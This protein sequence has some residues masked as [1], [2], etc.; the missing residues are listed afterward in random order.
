KVGDTPVSRLPPTTLFLAPALCCNTIGG[1][2]TVEDIETLLPP[3]HRAG[4]SR[5]FPENLPKILILEMQNS[6]LT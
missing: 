1:S 5:R 4:F 3:E 2:S 6:S